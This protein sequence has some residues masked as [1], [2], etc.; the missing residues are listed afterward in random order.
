MERGK[1]ERKSIFFIAAKNFCKTISLLYKVMM[2]T[3]VSFHHYQLHPDPNL[4]Q[5]NS[6]SCGADAMESILGASGGRSSLQQRYT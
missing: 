2:I 3:I 5:I 6:G 4:H 1:I